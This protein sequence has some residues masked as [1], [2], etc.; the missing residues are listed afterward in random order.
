MRPAIIGHRGAAAVAPENSLVGLELALLLGAD[1]LELDV[2]RSADGVLV[3]IHDPDLLRTSRSGGRVAEL[4]WAAIQRADLSDASDSRLPRWSEAVGVPTLETVFERFPGIE[5]TVDVKEPA[6]SDDVIQMIHRFD[7]VLETILYVEEGTETQSFR[8]YP[9]RR[10]TSVSQALRLATD[11]SWLQTGPERDIPEV[12]HTPLQE[13]GTT[14]VTSDLVSAIQC[15]GRT[16]QV[17]TIDDLPTMEWL[18]DCGVD[19]IITNDVGT[20]VARF[21]RNSENEERN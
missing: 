16:I 9:G 7:R 6:A 17:W 12:V 18:A 11:R 2:R 4:P 10:A 8:E 15:S 1:A 5:I 20:A 13:G 14:I 21:G 3:V 19:G